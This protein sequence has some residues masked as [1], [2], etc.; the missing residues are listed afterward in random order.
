MT[1]ITRAEKPARPE[2]PP[3][4]TRYYELLHEYARNF[5]NLAPI[6]ERGNSG[7][8][9]PSPE[10][11]CRDQAEVWNWREGRAEYTATNAERLAAFEVSARA[12]IALI[13]ARILS[14]R[15][16]LAH[17]EAHR[18]EIEAYR[19]AYREWQTACDEIDRA[20]YEARN[21][22]IREGN[23]ANFVVGVRVHPYRARHTWEI[24]A[25]NG[26]GAI[27]REVRYDDKPARVREV[28]DVLEVA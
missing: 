14:A 5:Q 24:I 20:Y 21:E 23:R 27:I 18:A 13:E 7:E 22:A 11:L 2:S 15:E 12:S 3:V 8:A 28:A 1:E 19:E 26:K 6:A 9:T 17:S 25:R 4:V 10:L 16:L